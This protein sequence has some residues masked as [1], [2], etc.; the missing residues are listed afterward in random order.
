M[1]SHRFSCLGEK[2]R[3]YKYLPT[4]ISDRSCHPLQVSTSKTP[5][6]PAL[7]LVECRCGLG[8]LGS[9]ERSVRIARLELIGFL[10]RWGV[11]IARGLTCSTILKKKGDRKCE[12]LPDQ[13][14]RDMRRMCVCRLAVIS[15][16]HLFRGRRLKELASD[17][18]GAG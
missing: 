16:T 4:Y 14:A 6:K 18:S 7:P 5:N 17:V 3:T 2:C 9:S 13:G 15:V 11:A 12:H 10:N 1:S 8:K